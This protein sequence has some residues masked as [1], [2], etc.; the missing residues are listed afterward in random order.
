MHIS[1]SFFENY[2]LKYNLH[3]RI[4]PGFRKVVFDSTRMIEIQMQMAER[5]TE[6]LALPDE[7]HYLL[8]IG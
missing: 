1:G 7:P 6:L 3:T 2:V 5:A 8:D 4:T